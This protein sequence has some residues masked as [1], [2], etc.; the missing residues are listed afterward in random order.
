MTI[1]ITLFTTSNKSSNFHPKKKHNNALNKFML[2][3]SPYTET[4]KIQRAQPRRNASAPQ[5]RKDR[6]RPRYCIPN[7]ARKYPACVRS[8][9]H[10]QR[11]EVLSATAADQIKSDSTT[12]Y[13][14]EGGGFNHRL[15]YGRKVV[16]RSHEHSLPLGSA[17]AKSRHFMGR[18]PTS[19]VFD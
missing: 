8:V 5:S 6:A 12:A 18:R 3:R 2:H 14:T 19:Y 7:K 10:A 17:T 4:R 16:V 9:A 1:T 15:Q 11:G 13:C